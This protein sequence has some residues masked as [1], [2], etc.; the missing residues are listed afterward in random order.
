MNSFLELK[1]GKKQNFYMVGM[2][3]SIHLYSEF[4]KLYFISKRA[5]GSS[6]MTPPIQ[7]YLH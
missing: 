3:L 7:S 4:P 1:I 6:T 2:L 5:D